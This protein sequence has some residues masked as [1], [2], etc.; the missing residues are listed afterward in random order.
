MLS[1]TP[2]VAASRWRAELDLRFERRGDRTVMAAQRHQGPLL[3]QKPLYP[4][5]PEVCQVTVLHP[6]GGIAAGDSMAISATLLQRSHALLTTPGATKWYRSGGALAEQHTRFALQNQSILE[7]LPRE[8]ILF[9][10]S[11]VSI[12]LDV[13]LDGDAKFLGWEILCFGRRASA[14]R[15]QHGD[16]RLRTRIVRDGRLLWQ[17]SGSIAAD[18]GF[19]NSPVGLAGCSV[20]GT[21]VLAGIDADATALGACR[22]IA[23]E[24]HEARTGITCVPGVLVARYLGDS[25]EHAFQ[26][27][28]QLWAALR[29]TLIG[30]DAHMLRLWAC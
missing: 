9:D 17:E 11:R 21:F 20:M 5:G 30:R 15:W 28:T 3:V 19:T 8:S 6:P 1:E 25:S 13:Q 14:E 2:T 7:W 18:S 12:A 10:R 27:F 22:T 4:Q 16:L 26:W 29:P 23:A 24:E